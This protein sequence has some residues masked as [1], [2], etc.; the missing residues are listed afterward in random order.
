MKSSNYT[1][2]VSPWKLICSENS[3]HGEFIALISDQPKLLGILDFASKPIMIRTMAFDAA[4][5]NDIYDRLLGINI[6]K[7]IPKNILNLN[8]K[9]KVVQTQGRTFIEKIK[10]KIFLVY[11]FL[12]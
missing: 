3:F 2:T 10:F 6:G 8:D 11:S 5:N 1:V 7:W 12:L 4:D 9:H